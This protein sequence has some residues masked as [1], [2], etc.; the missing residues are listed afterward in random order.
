MTPMPTL[1]PFSALFRFIFFFFQNICSDRK[2][3]ATSSCPSTP[4]SA[5]T[6]SSKTGLPCF[7]VP[8]L[9]PQAESTKLKKPDKTVCCPMSGKPLKLKNLFEVKFTELRKEASDG[10]KSLIAREE[11][12]KCPV[13]NDVLR[14]ITA[15]FVLK[16]TGECTWN[17]Y[18]VGSH[19]ITWTITK[20]IERHYVD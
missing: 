11:R 7:W 5:S 1:L 12:Y 18:L 10:N 6:S 17:H 9:T 2:S 8:N 3:S 4:S 19:R 16:P 13:T 14:N 15:V 20:E